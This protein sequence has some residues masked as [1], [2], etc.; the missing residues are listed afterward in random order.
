MFDNPMQM[1]LIG[2]GMIVTGFVLFRGARQLN[3]SRRRNLLGEAN[4]EILR[5]E[6]S[7]ESRVQKMEVRL[8]EYQREVEAQIGTKMEALR[9]LTQ[10]AETQIDK[11]ETLLASFHSLNSPQESKQNIMHNRMTKQLEAAGFSVDEISS[12]LKISSDEVR[13][14]LQPEQKSNPDDQPKN[15]A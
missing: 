11:L 10:S 5:A 1:I 8:L 6:K 14:L 7:V 13:K 12:L 9:Q 15:V 3:Q 4:Q 2:M